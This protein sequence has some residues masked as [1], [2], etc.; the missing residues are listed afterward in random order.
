MKTRVEHMFERDR[1]QIEKNIAFISKNRNEIFRV[2][3]QFVKQNAN[4]CSIYNV[5]TS[6][7]M[8]IQTKNFANSQFVVND[9]SKYFII[10]VIYT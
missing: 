7:L 2:I 9:I 5:C 1:F 3:V 6:N 8:K 4:A 10:R